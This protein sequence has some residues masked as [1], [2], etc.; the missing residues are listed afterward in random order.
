MFDSL[1]YSFWWQDIEKWYHLQKQTVNYIHTRPETY[2]LTKKKCLNLLFYKNHKI[3]LKI[4]QCGVYIKINT[5]KMFQ[6][7][8]SMN[9]ILEWVSKV[10]GLWRITFWVIAVWI[11]VPLE[12]WIKSILKHTLFCLSCL[13]VNKSQKKKK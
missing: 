8:N 6:R 2:N 5:H 3:N 13:R 10:V 4:A 11:S 7:L 12:I 1:K 9:S